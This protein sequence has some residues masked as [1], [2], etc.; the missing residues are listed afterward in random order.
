MHPEIARLKQKFA[1]NGFPQFAKSIE[2]DGLR[3]F[4]NL[5]IDF[6]FPVFAL[7]GENGSGKTTILKSLACVYEQIDTKLVRSFSP[8]RFFMRTFWD[9]VS[10]V[11][12]K[13]IVKNGNVDVPVHLNKPTERW[14]GLDKR[15]KREVHFFDISRTMPID[16]FGWVCANYKEKSYRFQFIRDEP[17]I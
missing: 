16:A 1:T 14:R 9:N 4:S 17:R 3:G 12:I 7:V 5:N 2:I 13:S 6:S 15:P 8:G 10:A 11:N